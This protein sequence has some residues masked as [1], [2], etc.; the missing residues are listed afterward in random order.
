MEMN[1]TRKSDEKTSGRRD[2][3]TLDIQ[4]GLWTFDKVQLL[5]EAFILPW[6]FLRIRIL[7][8]SIFVPVSS[9]KCLA[10][11]NIHLQRM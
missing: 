2:G 8:Q 3:M 1:L 11:A 5:N 6:H 4:G 9:K 10:I 7:I